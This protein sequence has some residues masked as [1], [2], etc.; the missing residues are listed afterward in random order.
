VIRVDH[1]DFPGLVKKDYF[2]DA[3]QLAAQDKSFQPNDF[4]PM[5]IREGT[6]QNR[7]YGLNTM[8]GGE[9]MYYNRTLFQKAG[10]EDP[11]DLARQG[12]WT[13]DRFRKSAIALSQFDAN[14]RARQFGFQIPNFPMYVP[15]LWGFGAD[16]LSPDGKRCLLDS[17]AAAEAVQFLADLRWK[18]HC[19]PSPAQSEQSA[20]GFESGKIGMTVD[21]SG[22]SVR[23]R[24]TIKDF[25]WDVCPLP[26]G[27]KSGDSIVKGN[28]LVI[29]H[30]SAHPDV[31]W[32]FIRY[33]TRRVN[34]SPIPKSS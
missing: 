23:Y 29:Y 20:F 32:R 3:T 33:L 21:W 1:Y 25:E 11:N 17:P 15:F 18:D 31:A 24:K 16:V 7:F 28:Q 19:S 14:G 34:R 27:P 9:V 22:N 5:T 2:Y 13:F 6:Y 8:F 4:F 30:E 26:T 10:L 12:G